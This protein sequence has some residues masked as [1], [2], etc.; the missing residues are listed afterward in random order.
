MRDFGSGSSS[1]A[2]LTAWCLAVA[3]ACLS[4]PR[5][6]VA[7]HETDSEYQAEQGVC[8]GLGVF[9]PVGSAL[10]TAVLG[11]PTYVSPEGDFSLGV[12]GGNGGLE[13]E[14]AAVG[15]FGKFGYRV[16][17][18]T[19]QPGGA[20]PLDPWVSSAISMQY[21]LV[22][23]GTQVVRLAG[24]LGYSLGSELAGAHLRIGLSYGRWLSDEVWV[25]AR[26]TY[27]PHLNTANDGTDPWDR[28]TLAHPVRG[29][30]R[31]RLSQTLK[32]QPFV[33]LS[34]GTLGPP[35]VGHPHAPKY[36]LYMSGLVGFQ[37][38]WRNQRDPDVSQE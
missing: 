17:G 19:V 32:A 24:G 1:A 16:D 11:I 15:D 5:P 22:D 18:F 2:R 33:E 8:F 4:A 20:C 3:L 25:R 34:A 10:T 12:G 29:S 21:D 35:Y 28:R 9:L 23:D 6:A 31:L 38:G 26:A 14:G 7:T 13:F 30:L 27:Y 37:F 36:D